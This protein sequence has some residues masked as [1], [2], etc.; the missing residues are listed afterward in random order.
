MRESSDGW[1]QRK[2]TGSL[3]YL[4]PIAT[5]DLKVIM[6]NHLKRMKNSTYYYEQNWQIKLKEIDLQSK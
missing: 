4:K 5:A 3:L 6:K 2:L 1:D